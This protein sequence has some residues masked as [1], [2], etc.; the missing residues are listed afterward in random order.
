[1]EKLKERWGITSNF[2]IV[3]IFIVFAIN[4]SF[5]AWVAEP[6]TNFFGLTKGSVSGW[7]YWP[8]RI[9]LIFP[10]YQITLPIVGFCF[11]QFK[12]FWDFEKKF[13]TKMGFGF[14]FKKDSQ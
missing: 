1:M 4:G 7:I 3:L 10:I 8:L 9:I 2:Q 6:V 13:L 12:F 14:L 11:G 5:S